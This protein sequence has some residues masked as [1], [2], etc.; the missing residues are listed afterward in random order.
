[1]I[2]PDKIIADT[3]EV[4]TRSSAQRNKFSSLENPVDEITY[5]KLHRNFLTP[6]D[7]KI[8]CDLFKK[9]IVKYHTW[10]EPWGNNHL[11]RFGLAL[12]NQDG[13]LKKNDPVNGSLYEWNRNN[14]NSPIFESDCDIP[15]EAMNI[16][17]LF[18]L[19]TF[20]SLWFRSNILK[21]NRGAEFL[22]HIDTVI[23]SPWL[24]LWA[25]TD[26]ISLK[27]WNN[28]EREIVDIEK[29]RI[30]LVDTSLVHAAKSFVDDSYQL[31]LSVSP[32]A[33]DKISKLIMNHK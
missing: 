6:L 3:I 22:P 21:W 15:T 10:F 24:R 33:I 26:D 12:V 25:T 14:P 27:C 9:E 1:M 30:Y 28:Q 11:P 16:S 2:D 31:F 23:P 18:P 5:K 19:R 13:L 29:G 17:S 4:F 8:D 7:L 20:D 32:R